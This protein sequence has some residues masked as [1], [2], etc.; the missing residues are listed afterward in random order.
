MI[1]S[2]TL[3]FVQFASGDT[4]TTPNLWSQPTIGAA[5][6]SGLWSRRIPLIQAS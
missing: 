2:Q 3:A 5:A 6:R 4:F 1:A